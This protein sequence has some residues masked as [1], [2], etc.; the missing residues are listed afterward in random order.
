MVNRPTP[1][2]ASAKATFTETVLVVGL[3]RMLTTVVTSRPS[4]HTS[5][6]QRTTPFP[7]KIDMF[8][9]SH[10][11]P[12]PNKFKRTQQQG[13]R[14]GRGTPAVAVKSGFYGIRVDQTVQQIR[15]LRHQ[16]MQVRLVPSMWATRRGK[17]SEEHGQG[18]RSHDQLLTTV[19]CIFICGFGVIELAVQACVVRIH[20]GNR[21]LCF[22]FLLGSTPG[23]FFPL[24]NRDCVLCGGFLYSLE[25]D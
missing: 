17:A 20:S 3:T 13:D 9:L 19:S 4:V 18:T 10:S 7:G 16:S 5:K 14:P 15:R 22:L 25:T 6:L 8:V 11:A 12:G 1:L 23:S 21:M 24:S 2:G